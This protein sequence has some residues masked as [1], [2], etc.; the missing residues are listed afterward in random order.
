M[1]VL[2]LGLRVPYMFDCCLKVMAENV[3]HEEW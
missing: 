3:F 1:S 2:P